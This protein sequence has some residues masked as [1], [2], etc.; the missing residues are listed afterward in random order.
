MLEFKITKKDE[1][2]SARLGELKITHGVVDTPIF[3]P[4]GTLATVKSLTPED[5]CEMGIKIILSNTYHLYLRPGEDLVEKA[6][7][8]HSFMNWKHGV[9]TD[10]GGFQVFSLSELRQITD[11]G[12]Y[13]NSHIDG[14]RH[15][16]TPEKV[17][18]IEQKLGADIAMCFDECPP[19]PC[20][21]KEVLKAV[22]RTSAWAKRC[23]ESHTRT[24]QALFGIVQGGVFEELR[25]KSAKEI[26]EVEFPG[27]AVGGLS[28]GEPKEDMYAMLQVM[29]ESLP[30]EKP[31][32]LMGVGAPEDLVEGVK[33]G[34]DMFDCVLPTRLA[35]H[36]TAYTHKGK[37]TVR[38]AKYKDDF[39]PIDEECGCYVCKNYTRAYIRHLIKAEEILAPRLLSYH[40]VYFLAKLME[41]IRT[42]ILQGEFSGFYNNFF[43][44]YQY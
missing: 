32:Y 42:A 35:R 13:F 30:T 27:Y 4:V 33:R 12:V 31:R 38:N 37:I 44:N 6:G 20:T 1:E 2:T 7:G 39:T 26:K 25:R 43:E 10:S 14:S 41:N 34:I 23:K 18:D 15:F 24:D 16:F 19:Y 11:D 3:M 29:D 9:L 36:G 21:Y 22:E 5:L 40:N 8:L 28:V 17:M